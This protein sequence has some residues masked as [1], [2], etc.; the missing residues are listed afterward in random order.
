MKQRFNW[1]WIAQCVVVLVCA[2]T[3]KQYYSTASADQLR[4]I[5]APTTKCV[6]L[7]SGE[8]FE[9]EFHAGYISRD[10]TFL[11]AASCAG[12]NFLITAFLMLAGRKLLSAWS[13]GI[14]WGFIPAAALIAYLVTVVA[15][16]SRIALALR[17][18]RVPGEIA[19]LSPSQ[20]HRFEGIFIYFGFLLLLFV[21]SESM[22][23]EKTSSLFRQSLFPLLVYYATMLGI[24]LA[25][26]AYRQGTDFWEHS[27][28][29]LLIPLVLILP[30]AAFRFW[31]QRRFP[32]SDML[33]RKGCPLEK[34]DFDLLLI[35]LALK[36]TTKRSRPSI[37]R[38][39]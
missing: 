8:S 31:R 23:S 3:L 28:F 1:N 33:Q 35:Q 11:I 14:S 29:V 17:L 20:I 38:I 30:F 26:G 16:T 34:R 24:P 18:E 27:L 25:N 13:K 36:T 32:R 22:S 4:W 7:V 12:V 37:D 5:L 19:G 6:E 10:R 2:F 15:N 9:F 39:S 21:V